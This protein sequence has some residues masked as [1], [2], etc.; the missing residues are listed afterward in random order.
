LRRPAPI[1]VRIVVAEPNKMQGQV[2]ASAFER[3][4]YRFVVES[5]EVDSAGTLNAVGEKQPDVAVISAQ[6][7]D[8]PSM[9]FRVA[10]ELRNLRPETR[11][12]LLLDSTDPELVVDAFRC[13]ARGIVS[14]ESS[15]DSLCKC[16]YVVSQGQLWA[17]TAQLN[18]VMEAFA[19]A[20]PSRVKDWKGDHPLTKRED[21]VVR[22]I[23]E[24]MTTHE[25]SERLKLTEH[26]VRNYLFR[27]FEKLGISS[28]VE[29][30]LYAMNQTHAVERSEAPSA[31]PAMPKRL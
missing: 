8:G 26:T 17:S 6:L 14:R 23:A 13:G 29:L 11:T 4:S 24:G 16:V 21:E 25:I 12:V 28:R 7:Q 20:A 15:F 30:V 1:S 10:R 2:V 9:G 27:I 18:Y 22:L 3:S 19:G 5:C 31:A